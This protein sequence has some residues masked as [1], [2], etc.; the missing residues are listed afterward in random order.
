MALQIHPGRYLCTLTVHVGTFV[1]VR[2]EKL[3]WLR[4]AGTLES[5]GQALSLPLDIVL[6]V[7]TILTTGPVDVTS[8]VLILFTAS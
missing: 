7:A 1:E 8:A 6:G 3:M 4:S 2:H 5:F